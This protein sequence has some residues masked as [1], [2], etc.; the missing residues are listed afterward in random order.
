MTDLLQRLE[1]VIGLSWSEEPTEESTAVLDRELR[2][3][4]VPWRRR[5]LVIMQGWDHLEVIYK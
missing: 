5:D 3:K 1:S 2:L 4:G